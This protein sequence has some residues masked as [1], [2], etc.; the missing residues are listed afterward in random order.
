[1]SIFDG[2]NN[3]NFSNKEIKSHFFLFFVQKSACAFAQF[4][5]LLYFCAEV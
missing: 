3:H 5:F 2:K 4:I 1:M